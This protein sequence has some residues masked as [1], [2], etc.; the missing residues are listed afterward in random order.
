MENLQQPFFFSVPKR[1]P[2]P[3][4]P[5]PPLR[6]LFFPSHSPLFYFFSLSPQPVKTSNGWLVVPKNGL[7]WKVSLLKKEKQLNLHSIYGPPFLSADAVNHF[8]LTYFSRFIYIFFFVSPPP[9]T[10]LFWSFSPLVTRCL[11][12]DQNLAPFKLTC[13]FFP[14]VFLCLW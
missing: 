8:F 10:I 11:N 9:P 14:S 6:W 2:P 1:S 4:S 12:D 7:I 13:G 3:R 5:S